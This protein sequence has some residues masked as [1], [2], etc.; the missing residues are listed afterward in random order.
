[1]SDAKLQERFPDLHGA[2]TEREADAA[3]AQPPGGQLDAAR[4]GEAHANS[5]ERSGPWIENTWTR[6]YKAADRPCAA[7]PSLPALHRMRAGLPKA[8]PPLPALREHT[9][10]ARFA[11]L[12]RM[13]TTLKST[14]LLRI[15]S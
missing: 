1:V 9:N 11:D 15:Q 14:R 7:Q 4:F 13:A 2:R 3:D 5:A 8:C 10:L 12:P 6:Q